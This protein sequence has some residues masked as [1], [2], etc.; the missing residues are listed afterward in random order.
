MTKLL[1]M[2]LGFD[3]GSVRTVD[4]NGF[5]HVAVS[6]ISKATVNPYNGAEIPDAERF[7][8]DPGKVYMLLRDPK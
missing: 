7:G 3:R 1:E 4:A 6:N 5:L 8:L 2:A